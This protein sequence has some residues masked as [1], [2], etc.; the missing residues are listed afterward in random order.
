MI[1]TCQHKPEHPALSVKRCEFY[2][3]EGD[4]ACQK[5]E[6]ARNI[7]QCPSCGAYHYRKP[8]TKEE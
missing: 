7:K 8:E 3:S 4:P 1:V 2:L 5:C 6:I